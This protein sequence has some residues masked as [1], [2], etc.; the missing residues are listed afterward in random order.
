LEVS[1][2]LQSWLSL[3]TLPTSTGWLQHTD[4]AAPFL[5][6]RFYRA[7]QLAETNVVT[8]DHLVTDA[9][10]VIIH[11]INHATFV[12][13]WNGKAI[14]VDPVGGAARF[15]D[16]PRADWILITHGHSDH[17]DAS[18]ITAVKAT[19]AVIVAPQAVYQGLSSSLRSIT[20]TMTNGALASILGLAIEA[21]PM[22]NLTA[23][24]HPRGNGNGYVL[25]IG[26][27]RIYI[28]G[29]TDNTAEVRALSEIN[30]AFVCMRPPYTMDVA[31]AASATRSFRPKVVYPYHY[32]GNDVNKFK[33]L[34]G[35]DL[36]IEVRLRNW[37]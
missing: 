29:D 15:Q 13:S 37:Y 1:T 26:G 5:S 12:M 21:V 24:N 8:G 14:Y 19:N 28:S 32:Q 2:N 3:V 20:T 10:E 9:G 7:L 27:R 4:S 30:V 6:R 23:A 35:L 16:L 17:L 11:P 31:Q 18:T 36:A 33:Q 25:T 34:V 22:Y